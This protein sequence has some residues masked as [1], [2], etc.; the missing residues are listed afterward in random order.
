MQVDSPLLRRLALLPIQA[1]WC[2]R[3]QGGRVR[4]QSA[5]Q[6]NRNILS[7]KVYADRYRLLATQPSVRNAEER[8]CSNPLRYQPR[9][10]SKGWMPHNDRNYEMCLIFLAKSFS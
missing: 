8:R 2:G 5:P 4:G 9:F 6:A 7:P 1:W 10:E 3:P